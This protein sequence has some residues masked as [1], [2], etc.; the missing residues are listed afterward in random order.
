MNWTA[1]L[2]HYK[3]PQHPLCR[4]AIVLKS[5][6]NFKGEPLLD[7]AVLKEDFAL[8][9]PGVQLYLKSSV[10]HGPWNHYNTWHQPM[11][12]EQP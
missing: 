12:C 1:E 5:H 2:A 11:E 7:L 3:D 4:A 6:G 8:P 9:T 10:P